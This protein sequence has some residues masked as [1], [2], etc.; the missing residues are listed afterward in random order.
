MRQFLFPCFWEVV[1]PGTFLMSSLKTGVVNK[2]AISF[3]DEWWSIDGIM[4]VSSAYILPSECLRQF[5]RTFIYN[6]NRKG[7]GNDPCGT[8]QFC[9]RS[10]D[11]KNINTLHFRLKFLVEYRICLICELGYHSYS[12]KV[13]FARSRKISTSKFP[14][15]MDSSQSNG[16]SIMKRLYKF[17]L[18]A[19]V[20][21]FRF[22]NTF[23]RL[24]FCL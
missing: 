19:M 16:R 21:C 17:K 6:R 4:F 12:V 15:S 9:C 23:R 7:P 8:L 11:K 10:E 5:G 3:N 24:S 13:V 14:W 18:N 2:F 22:W 20:F 1:V